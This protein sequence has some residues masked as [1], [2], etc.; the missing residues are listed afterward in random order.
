MQTSR[1]EPGGRKRLKVPERPVRKILDG[2]RSQEQDS[3]VKSSCG[4][5]AVSHTS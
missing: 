3:G 4:R 1:E 2:K 5:R